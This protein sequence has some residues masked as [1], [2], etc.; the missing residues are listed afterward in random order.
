MK[1]RVLLAAILIAT[2]AGLAPQLAFAAKIFQWV[3][4][5]GVSHMSD[6]M[7]PAVA[8][9]GYKIM[10]T[11]NGTVTVI[12]PEPT[13]AELAAK[14]E[15]KVQ[16]QKNEQAEKAKAIEQELFDE[17]FGSIEQIK[18]HEAKDLSGIDADIK[19]L[20]DEIS[21]LGNSGLD[22]DAQARKVQRDQPKINALY[23]KKF[24]TQAYYKDVYKRFRSE[25]KNNQGE[26]STPGPT[27]DGQVNESGH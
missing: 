19:A 5:D 24:E 6:N 11:S 16:V 26:I 7:P 8:A 15:A 14:A 9:R 10:D 3:T 21:G 4:P 17:K 2:G 23:L 12:P 20:T 27:G 1:N 25:P 13:K 22:P 18:R